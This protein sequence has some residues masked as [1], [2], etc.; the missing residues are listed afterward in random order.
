MSHSVP[1]EQTLTF[2]AKAFTSYAKHLAY[3]TN[4][5]CNVLENIDIAIYRCCQ[6]QN[7]AVVSLP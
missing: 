7:M 2:C 5:L 1:L 3:D 4:R 6:K